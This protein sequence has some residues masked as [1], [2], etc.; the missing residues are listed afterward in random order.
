MS[1]GEKL[2]L[3]CGIKTQFKFT[4]QDKMPMNDIEACMVKDKKENFIV[5]YNV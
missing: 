1:D 4:G 5:A 3:S 2:E